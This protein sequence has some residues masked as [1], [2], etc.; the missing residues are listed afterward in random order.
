MEILVL[1]PIILIVTFILGEI[2]KRIGL[3]T[4]IGQILAGLIFGLPFFKEVFFDNASNLLI[5]EF[6]GTLGIVL[7]LFLAGLEIDINQIKENSK[8]SI[9]ICLGSV[10][11]PFI[12]GFLFIFLVFP[13]YGILTAIIFGG[14]MMV[15]SEGTKVKVLM[16]L[17][18]LNTRLGAIMLSAGAID[19]IFE[20]LLL[21]IVVLLAKGEGTLLDVLILPIEIVIFLAIAFFCFKLMKKV[22]K[23]LDKNPS[24]DTALFSVVMIFILVLAALSEALHIGYLVGAIL[25]GFL[26][27]SSMKNIAPKNKRKMINVIKLIALGFIV[28]FFFVHIGISLDLTSLF[29]NS[30]LIIATVIIAFSGTMIGTLII[31]PFS[32]LTWKQLYYA[33]WGMNS[34]GAAELVVALLALQYGLIPNE[35]FSALVAMSIITTLSFAPILARGIKRN[36]GLMNEIQTKEK[37]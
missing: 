1:I 20:V 37:P 19:D 33:G 25:G 11:V 13:Q 6:L 28:P 14:A 23:Y 2:F 10:A 26:L 7:L 34:R 35:I 22:L 31:K 16:D 3:P 27:Q 17:N 30:Y 32:T 36:P 12:F 8:D 29:S 21:S 9:L 4:V 5:V 15:T 24:D 18:S